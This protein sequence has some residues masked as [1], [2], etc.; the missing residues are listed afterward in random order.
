MVAFIRRENLILL[1]CLKLT[2]SFR[3]LE[4]M[5]SFRYSIY[6]RSHVSYRLRQV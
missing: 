2:V 6:D 3:V 5:L 1:F 4:V